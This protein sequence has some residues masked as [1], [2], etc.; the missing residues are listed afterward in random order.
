M[1]LKKL[2][3]SLVG[4]ATCY[5]ARSKACCGKYD[6]NLHERRSIPEWPKVRTARVPSDRQSTLTCWFLS[7][8][9]KIVLRRCPRFRIVISRLVCCIYDSV[10]AHTS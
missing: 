4:R 2:L 8:S 5:H 10:V 6:E 1:Q 3:W 7:D 9:C